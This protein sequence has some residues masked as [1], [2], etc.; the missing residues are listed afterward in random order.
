MKHGL[1]GSV[2]AGAEVSRRT[3]GKSGGEG[4]EATR[5]Q[6]RGLRMRSRGRGARPAVNLAAPA[7]PA[8]C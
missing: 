7:I 8:A 1:W 2:G 4:G 5:L 6:L 3:G